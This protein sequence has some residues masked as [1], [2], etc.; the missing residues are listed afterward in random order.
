MLINS[1]LKKFISL[2]DE[3]RDVGL[4]SMVSLPRI[5]VTGTQSAGKSSL[6]ENIVGIDFL[7]RGDGVCTRRPLELRLVKTSA[8]KMVALFE[9]LPGKPIEDKQYCDHWNLIKYMKNVKNNIIVEYI[10]PEEKS[11]FAFYK[12]NNKETS[13]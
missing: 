8:Q 13:A 12:P 4:S 9:E 10:T 11:T 6:L 2:V 3:L 5:I 1:D 7:P